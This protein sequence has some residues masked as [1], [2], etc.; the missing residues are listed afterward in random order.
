MDL[1]N[2]TLFG[3]SRTFDIVNG[4]STPVLGLQPLQYVFG[5]CCNWPSELCMGRHD[6]IRA[7]GCSIGSFR[8]V[9]EHDDEHEGA[10]E[11]TCQHVSR[12]SAIV[13]A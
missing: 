7:A 1:N 11:T 12:T 5:G 9:D 13:L 3:L 4:P 6:D 8:D 10:A 2:E